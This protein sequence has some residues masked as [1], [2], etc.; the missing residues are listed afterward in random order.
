MSSASRP[1]RNRGIVERIADAVLYEG[2]ILYPYRPSAVKNQQRF[3]FGVLCPD[4]Y[5]LAHQVSES[6][7][8]RTECLIEVDSSSAL[9]VK[10]RFLHLI[11][12]EVGKLVDCHLPIAECGHLSA[13]SKHFSLVSTL[14]VNDQILQPWQEA[15]E[16]EV[17]L[18][19]IQ[20][21][22]FES[23]GRQKFEFPSSQTLEVVRDNSS[24]E[25]AGLLVRTQQSLAG[26]IEISVE[27]P[28]LR[29]VSP[30]NTANWQSAI[31]ERQLIKLSILIKNLSAFENSTDQ[32]RD[33][34]L[35][36]SF[37]STHTI[38]KMHNGS[39]ISLLDPPEPYKA[40]VA[41]CTNVGTFPVLVGA[42]GDREC[43]L[44]SPIILYDYPQIAAESAGD[45]FDGTEI[46]E[47]LT[48]RIMSLTD[49]EKTEVR[50]A[51]ALA[52]RLLERTESMS[53][54]QLMNLH[55][56]MKRV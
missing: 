37:V 27:R 21:A 34:A 35:M 3:N 1:V 8:M 51:D 6:S 17:V 33:D 36:R 14:E 30:D 40:G 41:D 53:A 28:V 13:A 50:S 48:L 11:S 25:L 26:E 32:K 23:P 39:F 47:I 10:I 44:S 7:L 54:E 45:L 5:A 20:L 56:G 22:D 4:S 49:A 24:E 29:S 52:R 42:E 31:G 55:G 38:L 43:M 16:R 2:Y 18:Q 9:D 15:V 19:R 12:R 46:D